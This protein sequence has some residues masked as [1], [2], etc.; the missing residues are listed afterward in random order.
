MNA[1]EDLEEY[2]RL[3]LKVCIRSKSFEE[4]TLHRS[5]ETIISRQPVMVGF[6]LM[7][8]IT[9]PGHCTRQR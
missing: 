2:D 3:R 7:Q 8:E 9:G 6:M 5:I 4:L 1:L